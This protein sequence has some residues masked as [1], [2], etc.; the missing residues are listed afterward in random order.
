M[1]TTIMTPREV[2]ITHLH[3]SIA[4][5]YGEDDIP[6]DFPLRNGDTWEARINIDTGTIE[7]WPEGRTGELQT[8]VCDE[9]T[10]TLFDDTGAQVAKLENEYVPNHLVPGEFGDY[11]EL[12]IDE[13][14]VITNWPKRPQFTDFFPED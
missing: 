7:G 8:K 14:G 5:R 9:G 4:V 6:N 10:Y 3:M 12:N 2:N 1:K 11:V 13:R